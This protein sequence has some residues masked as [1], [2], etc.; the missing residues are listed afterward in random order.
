MTLSLGFTSSSV[1]SLSP[2]DELNRLILARECC[3]RRCAVPALHG[4]PERFFELCIHSGGFHM[5]G[6][7]RLAASRLPTTRRNG[8]CS[9]TAACLCLYDGRGLLDIGIGGGASPP[10]P[11]PPPPSELFFGGG[12]GGG[13]LFA[14]AGAADDDATV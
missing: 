6:R 11:P 1:K 14:I 8:R 12:G 13:F 9:T 4:V 5:Q 10:P 3:D 7:T 2:L